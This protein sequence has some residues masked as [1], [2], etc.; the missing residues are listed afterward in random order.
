[1]PRV[2][3]LKLGTKARSAFL[4]FTSSRLPKNSR[5]VVC[6]AMSTWTTPKR[7]AKNGKLVAKRLS[8]KWSRRRKA[9]RVLE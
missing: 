5:I 1:M 9:S 8:A 3:L 6:Q 4:T 7:T 2:T